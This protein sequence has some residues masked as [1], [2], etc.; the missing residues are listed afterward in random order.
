[1]PKAFPYSRTADGR[2]Y[3]CARDAAAIPEG[4]IVQ[5]VWDANGAL[6]GVRV[7]RVGTAGAIVTVH[8]CGTITG[9]SGKWSGQH[10]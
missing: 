9:L 6:T 1:M 5:G 10:G 4:C 7:I 3:Q 2:G 8:Q